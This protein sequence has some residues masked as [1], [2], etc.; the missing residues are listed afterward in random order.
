VA[1]ENDPPVVAAE[2]PTT[3]ASVPAGDLQFDKAEFSQSENAKTCA[4]CKQVIAMEYFEIAGN[5]VC[6]RCCDQV[7]GRAADKW[8]FVR[9][10][11][12]GA[13][14]G[15]IGTLVWS[16]IIH[17]TGYELG[18]IAIV[19]G[20]GVGKAV[21]KGSRGR[22]GWKYQALAMI[23]TYMSITTSYVPIVF[24]GIVQG[25]NKGKSDVSATGISKGETGETGTEKGAERAAA[26]SPPA[27]SGLPAPVA[28]LAF[29]AL[30]WGVALAAP[31]LAGV[32]NIMG[33]III[34]VGIYEAW[35]FNRRVPVSGP[36]KLAA[37]AAEP[38]APGSP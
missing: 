1:S 38:V 8:C 23:L 30:I 22:G 2:S 34:G 5:V 10:L 13:I 15:V 4:A 3:Q 6:P 14:A 19:V 16:L 20:I 32:S 28:I 7:T 21:R 36:F 31:F 24:K 27:K 26:A 12:Y 17:F 33:I 18:L 29:L 9:A 25:M 35:K 37:V 11:G